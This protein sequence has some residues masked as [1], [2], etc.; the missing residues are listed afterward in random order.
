[1]TPTELEIKT[2]ENTI[3]FI[4]FKDN[5]MEDEVILATKLINKWKKLTNWI[6]A[7]EYPIKIDENYLLN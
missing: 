2:I 4:F 5:L 7:I 1:M 6:E 3:K